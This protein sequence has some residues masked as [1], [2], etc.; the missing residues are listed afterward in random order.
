[1]PNRAWGRLGMGM[2][3][4]GS[5]SATMDSVEHRSRGA[6]AACTVAGLIRFGGLRVAYYL[7]EL[8]IFVL[9][10]SLYCRPL[11]VP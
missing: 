8:P 4:A 7:W 2:G 10:A 3:W 11:P 5:H 6:A 9:L 1:M